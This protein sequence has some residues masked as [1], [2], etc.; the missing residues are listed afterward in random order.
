MKYAAQDWYEL[1]H[2][3]L[4]AFNRDQVRINS[5]PCLYFKVRDD[6]YLSVLVHVD[7]YEVA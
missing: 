6:E 5:D 1:Q 7:D 4:V 3:K 2:C